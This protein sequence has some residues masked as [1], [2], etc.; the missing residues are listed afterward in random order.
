M[1]R[2]EH[3]FGSSTDPPDHRTEHAVTRTSTVLARED[4]ISLP[5]RVHKGS[6]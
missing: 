3:Y 2:Q 6:I 1:A 5:G 4:F